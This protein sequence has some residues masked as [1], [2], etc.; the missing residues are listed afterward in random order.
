MFDNPTVIDQIYINNTDHHGLIIQSNGDRGDSCS[1]TNIFYYLRS[2]NE[3]ENPQRDDTYSSLVGKYE[4]STNT[5]VRH[6]DGTTPYPDGT[7]PQDYV[8]APDRFSRDQQTPLVI[9]L[10]Q[11]KKEHNRLIRLFKT[12]LFRFG[13]YQNKDWLAPQHLGYYIRALNI[14]WLYSVMPILDLGLVVDSYINVY[15]RN[16]DPNDTSDSVNHSLALIQSHYV[17]PTFISKWAIKVFKRSNPQQA[18]D[19][20]FRPETN[21]PPLNE[22]FKPQMKKIGLD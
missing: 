10:G 20:Y 16:K 1:R 8:A 15:K 18:L 12:H 9:A 2:L 5:Y 3:G 4:I 13:K 19:S 22:L 6:P 17:M 21:A 7:M 14:K 11:H